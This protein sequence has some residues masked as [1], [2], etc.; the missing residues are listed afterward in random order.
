M[1][2]TE[3]N[4]DKITYIDSLDP[5]QRKKTLCSALRNGMC[6]RSITLMPG[7]RTLNIIV[8]DLAGNNISQS[9]PVS[10]N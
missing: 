6:D 9:I 1:N 7:I 8:R 4:F 10:I 2:I 5:S 3:I